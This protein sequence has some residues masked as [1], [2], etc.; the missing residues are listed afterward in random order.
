MIM[1]WKLN[2]LFDGESYHAMFAQ[3]TYKWFISRKWVTYADIMA[4]YLGLKSAKELTY[5]VSNC[6]NYGE[7][8]KAFRDV[9]KAIVEKVGEGC[10][11]IDGN[12]RKYRIYR[13]GC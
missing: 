11:E 3:V 13:R 8:K 7:L 5:N 1:P 4:D 12:N 6:D 9:C 10:F 2:N